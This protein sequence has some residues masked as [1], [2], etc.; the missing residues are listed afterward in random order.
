V[1]A[2]YT[3]Q[4]GGVIAEKA[5]VHIQDKILDWSGRPF[6]SQLILDETKKLIA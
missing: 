1:E 4:L 6:T 5:G 3:A 2:N